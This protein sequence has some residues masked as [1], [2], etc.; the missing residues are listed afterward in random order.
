MSPEAEI[1]AG[2][3]ALIEASYTAERQG[4]ISLLFFFSHITKNVLRSIP[5][6]LL[7]MAAACTSS[8]SSTPL[9]SE[10]YAPSQDRIQTP[11][12]PGSQPIF[13]PQQEPVEGERETMSAETFGTLVVIDGCIRVNH[14]ESD[15]SWL[16]IWPPD[17]TLD[18]ANDPIQILD[19]AGNVVVRVGDK[20]RVGG[21]EVL[22]PT[23]FDEKMKQ[24]LPPNCL[25]PYWIVG[26]KVSSAPSK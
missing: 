24:Q 11:S 14:D 6:T 2:I 22:S 15:T 3:H 19:E 21:G 5:V 8:P 1:P 9:P 12:S 16:L 17:F 25:A 10:I 4:N 26:D 20:V 7:I 23:F 13:F 18:T